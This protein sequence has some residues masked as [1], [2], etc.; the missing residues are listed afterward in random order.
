MIAEEMFNESARRNM[1]QWNKED[2]KKTHPKLYDSIIE[3]IEKALQ[4]GRKPRKEDYG[5][6]DQ[7]SLHDEPPS[8][9]IEGGEEA[10]YAALEKWKS[11]NL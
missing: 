3:S 10:Y 8:W 4:I 2:F 11:I 7:F 5:W 9:V 1:I 6:V